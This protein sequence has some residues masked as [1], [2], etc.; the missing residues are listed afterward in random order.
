M[1]V[2]DDDESVLGPRPDFGAPPPPSAA[3]ARAVSEMKPVRT[4]GRWGAFLAVA[5][6]GSLGPVV[7]FLGAPLR[8]DLGG[9]PLAW[10]VAGAALWG[11]GFTAALLAALVPRP[12]DVLPAPGRASAV[13]AV[14]M[15]ALLVFALVA[16]VDVPGLS[17]PTGGGHPSLAASC[18]HCIGVVFKVA[19]L[20]LLVGAIA[21]RRL[22]P[23]GGLR[24][25]LALGAAGGALGG[26]VLHFI[27]A[28]AGTAHVVLGHVGGL[29]LSAALGA[30]LVGA[31]V[32]RR[33]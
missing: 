33:R 27:C 20:V 21:L 28:V 1:T 22:V 3:L 13:S 18:L 31:V 14:V 25:G 30:A 7:A 4:R 23:V 15:A 8:V 11:V 5:L 19:A 29:V 32:G 6:I 16:T 10:V 9:L 26:F 2:R 24:V 17:T 12:R